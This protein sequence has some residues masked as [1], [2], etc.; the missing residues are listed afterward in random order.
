MALSRR[1]NRYAVDIWPGFVDVL[2]T[3]LIIILFL[4]MIFTLAQYYLS[5]T[6]SGRNEALARLNRQ[7]AE[8]GQ[9][10]ALERSNAATLQQSLTAMSQE[11][12][13]V[14]ADRALLRSALAAM[15]S[16]RDAAIEARGRLEADLAALAAARAEAERSVQADRET[17][18][19]QLRA[20]ESIR[21]DIAAL[22]AVRNELER[23]VGA[24]TATLAEREGEAGTL[25]DR[26]RS[27]EAAIADARERTLLAQREIEARDVRLR[28]LTD[29]TTETDAALGREQALTSDARAQVDLLNRQIAVLREQLARISVALEVSEAKAAEQQ[30]Q[31]VNLGNR[32]NLALASKVEELARYRSEFFGRLR[33]VLGDRRDIRIVGDRFV[34]QSEVLFESGQA[35][36]AAEGEA[37]I[38]RLAETLK[39][40][41]TRI[42]GE[43][44]W[45]LRVD[46]HTD[47]VPIATAQF[48]SNWHLSTA[49][50]ISVVEFLAARGIAPQRLA[51]TGFG[52]FQPLDPG[53]SADALRRN[54]RIELKLTER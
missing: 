52:E 36:L 24:L 40:I 5:E 2:A 25:R 47:R 35:T 18:E 9:M 20:L 46:G 44:N 8:L 23:R 3:L 31:I 45:I 41:A 34:F 1:A 33:E 22:Q 6:L 26:T 42:P 16:E 50:A 38:G 28:A 10:L 11:L 43:L 19:I 17:I 4:L 49:R 48:P 30:V 51:A 7:I 37:Q 32:L 54:R 15:T 12:I 27:L 21:R 13:V 39:E 14:D 53:T 29:R